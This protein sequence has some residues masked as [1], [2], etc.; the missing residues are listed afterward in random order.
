MGCWG[1][2][3]YENDS[4]SDLKAGFAELARLPIGPVELP[5]RL[6]D[7]CPAGRDP[8][9]EDYTGSWLTWLTCSLPTTW[10]TRRSSGNKFTVRVLAYAI[11]ATFPV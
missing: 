8:E 10:T 9:D 1:V 7:A 2:G 11:T 4:A 6:L 5:E 3:L